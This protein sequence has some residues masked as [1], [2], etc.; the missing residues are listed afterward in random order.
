MDC[1]F[2]GAFDLVAALVQ[3]SQWSTLQSGPLAHTFSGLLS[4][5]PPLLKELV[6]HS[7]VW[8]TGSRLFGLLARFLP[9]SEELVVHSPEWTTGSCFFL[10]FVLVSALF[11][12]SALFST[13]LLETR[14]LFLAPAP[15]PSSTPHKKP[16]PWCGLL[17]I[18]LSRRPD[19]G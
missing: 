7:P 12:A 13:L 2:F 11:P 19:V 9:F 10:A 15:T 3:G 14:A 17:P 8:T 5:F 16:A 6:V 1:D 18:T 4:R